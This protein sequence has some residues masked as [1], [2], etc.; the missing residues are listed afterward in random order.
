MKRMIRIDTLQWFIGS[1]IFL[2][3]ALMLIA[4]HKLT[5]HVFVPIQ[6]YLPWLGTLQVIGGTALIATAALAPRRSLTFLAHLIAGA[7]LLQAAIG[8]ILAGTWTGAAGFGT[9][10]LGT[11]AAPF[12]PRVRWQLPRETDLDWFAFLTGIRLT[13]DGLLILSPFNQQFAASL[14]DPIRPYLPIYGMAHLASGVGLLAVCWFP[15]RSRW[16]V[17]FVY[18]VAA[19][20]LWAWS[21]G[22]GIPTWNSLLYFGGLGTL[23][24]LSPWIRSRLPQL[25]HA[26]LRTQLLMT[27][28]GIVTLPIL[29]AVAWVTL[30]QEQ[31][32]I[33]RALTVQRTLAVALAQ[34]T[35]NYV[36]LHRAAINALAGQPNLS[37]LNASEQRELLQA[38]N[39]AYP[40]MVVFSTF[41][42]NGNAIARS[43]MN[44]PGPPIDE[45]PLYD[46]IRRTGEP[47]LEVLV[48]R[49]IQKPLFAFAA[50]ILENAQFA[51]VVSG[52]IESSRIAEQLSQ[53]SADADVIAYLVDA[54]GRVIAHPDAALVEAFTSYADRPSV[55]ALLTMNRSE[56]G[57]N[58]RKIGEIRYWDGS[59]WELAGY[60]KISGLN[61]GVVV[62]RPVAGVLGTVNAARDR[63]LG[64]L[65]LVTVAAL[66][67]GSILARRLTTP[68]TTL[69]HASAQ[70]ALG[71]L[72]A[73]LP[74]SNITEVAHLSAVFGEMRT[75]LARRTAERDRAEAK[76]QRSEARLRRLVESNIV[77]V[78]IANFDGAI[79]EANDAFLE[80]VG[81]SR[82]DLNQGRVNWATMSPPEYRQQDEAKI[83]EI[84]RTGACAPFEKEY[85]RQDG[86]RVPIWQVLPYCPIARIAVFALFLT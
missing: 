51:G 44:P 45:L 41:D 37:R 26:S 42:A 8:H 23:L 40:D 54:E 75:Y 57:E 46:T 5:T 58:P 33:N 13:L 17:Q 61:W 6:P 84:Q 16:F 85:L 50:P 55:Q 78:I 15:V 64:T 47:T 69:T 79:L 32:V 18:L 63:D 68:L 82:E 65:L 28:V 36:E 34:D 56:T 49:V 60:S 43:D 59:A 39:R 80:M 11:M 73:P 74:K 9:L 14:Y 72:T 20:V 27:L 77:G 86:S 7:S 19:G 30:P 38:V 62:E 22:L 70:L 21:L 24:A 53:A 12:L 76:L 4:P 29:F 31:A 1:Y 66:I 48:G 2:R 83:A 25:D 71:N 81:Y 10:A 67:I 52:A 3:G 35:E